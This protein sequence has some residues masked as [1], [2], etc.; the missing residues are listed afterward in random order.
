L[1]GGNTF[2]SG[3]P[4][5]HFTVNGQ[6][7]GDTVRL[8][9]NGGTVEVVATVRSIL[10]IHTLQVVQ[11]GQIVAATEEK[12]GAYEL[13]LKTSLKVEGHTWLA[14]RCAGPGYTAIQHHDEWARGIM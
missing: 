10:P 12:N 1:R 13:H 8:S 9:G 6:T 2:L 14:A 5:L 4:L 3:G 7:M 11:Q